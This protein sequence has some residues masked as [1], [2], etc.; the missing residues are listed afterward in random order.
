M[1]LK[2]ILTAKNLISVSLIMAAAFS[3]LI[4]HSPNFTSVGAMALFA[5]SLFGMS[6]SAL[7]VPVVAMLLTD[8]I[9][10][11]HSTQIFVYGSLVL[12]VLMGA[13]LLKDQAKGRKLLVVTLLSSILFFIVTNLGV[14]LVGGFYSGD[15][16][17]LV[18]CYI[19][20][21]PFFTNQVAGDLLFSGLLFYGYSVA[22]TRAQTKSR[23]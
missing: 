21:L 1:Y 17:G 12:S 6:F 7:L 22:I 3:R 2:N 16:K 5:G 19:M 9:L 20:A 8:F 23:V 14:W 18:E 13:T 10:G 11:F 15:I 4:P